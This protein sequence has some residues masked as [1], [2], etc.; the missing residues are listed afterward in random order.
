MGVFREAGRSVYVEY[1]MRTSDQPL[2]H[3]L[4][5]RKC[6]LPKNL[7]RFL[8]FFPFLL[9]RQVFHVFSQVWQLLWYSSYAPSRSYSMGN[10]VWLTFVW[11]RP[12]SR[13]PA[14]CELTVQR[15]AP[16]CFQAGSRSGLTQAPCFL[17]LCRWREES[18][19]CEHHC[20]MCRMVGAPGG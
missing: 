16:A 14:G 4:E 15:G 9:C 11:I 20:S 2:T 6:S 7:H 17:A 18:D 13:L 8:F 12:G 3:S 1:I 5:A 10:S 19:P